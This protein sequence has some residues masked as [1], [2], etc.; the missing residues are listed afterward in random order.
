MASG[1]DNDYLFFVFRAAEKVVQIDEEIEYV[2]WKPSDG[3]NKGDSH[4]QVMPPP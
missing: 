2:Q 3:E 4:Q 1:V